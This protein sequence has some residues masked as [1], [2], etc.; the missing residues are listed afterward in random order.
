[1]YLSE[2]APTIQYE[3]PKEADFGD[4]SCDHNI[5]LKLKFPMESLKI[6]FVSI[7]RHT[8]VY[9]CTPEH[10][11]SSFVLGSCDKGTEDINQIHCLVFYATLP[12]GLLTTHTRSFLWPEPHLFIM[13][14]LINYY[15]RMVHYHLPYVQPSNL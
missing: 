6:F 2:E 11:T 9:K 1:M 5:S 12:H 13:L 3:K 7:P 10:K 14:C 8:R 15:Q 4:L